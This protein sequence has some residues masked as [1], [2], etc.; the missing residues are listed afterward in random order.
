LLNSKE[1]LERTGISR[2]TLN[3]YIALGIVP[4][5]DVL[6]PEPDDGA[7]PRIG[8]FPEDT[9]QRI[10]EIQRLKNQG[11]SMAAIAEH[12]AHGRQPASRPD[13]PH[14]P[15]PSG[16]AAS[17]PVT[18][19]SGPPLLSIDQ[20][21]QPAWLVDRDFALVWA[22]AAGAAVLGR[23]Q[24]GASVFTALV[25]RRE[26]PPAAR[27]ELIRFHLAIAKQQGVTSARVLDGIA[28]SDQSQLQGL[29][30]AVAAM[31]ADAAAHVLIGGEG[32]AASV[33]VYAVQFREGILFVQVPVGA[34]AGDLS[35]LLAARELSVRDV[36]RSGRPVLSDVAV[37]AMDLQDA[38]RIWSTL[39]AEEY[40]ELIDQIWLTAEPIVARHKG[41][42]GKHPGDGMVCYFLPQPDTDYVWNALLAASE[43]RDAMRRVSK[44]WQ[45]RKGW[46]TELYLNVGVDEGQQWLGTLRSGRQVDFTM[47]GDTLN[48]ATRISDFARFGAIW[49]TKNLVVKLAAEV[50]QR[51][52]YGVHRR[53]KKGR[54][55]FVSSVFAT[56]DRLADAAG[57]TAARLQDIARLP[58]TEI[59]DVAAPAA[60]R[61]RPSEPNPN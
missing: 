49:A 55:A 24:A 18:V 41:T 26:A 22:N 9:V 1:L 46:T 17:P 38:T 7:A 59:V 60:R 35:P 16:R 15:A 54:H 3:N 21:V 14:S 50:K 23:P 47:F 32:A 28:P 4:K 39:P 48:R 13:A 53:D 31:P 11:W 58:I 8:Y 40:F 61:E 27:E 30:A 20:I 5:P 52:K 2:A 42:P 33:C 45:L 51:L 37:L 6:P 10:A 56:P 29:Y 25:A 57:P 44:E 12:F 36:A 43:I 34:A 19:R